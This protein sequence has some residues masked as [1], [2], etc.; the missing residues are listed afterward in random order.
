MLPRLRRYSAP[1]R[2]AAQHSTGVG[3]RCLQR[4][5]APP[6]CVCSGLPP[7][8]QLLRGRG[9]R[10]VHLIPF[11]AAAAVPPLGRFAAAVPATLLLRYVCCSPA[12][13]QRSGRCRGGRLLHQEPADVGNGLLHP[14]ARTNLL[15][16]PEQGAVAPQ[17]HSSHQRAGCAWHARLHHTHALLAFPQQWQQ[18]PGPLP[19]LLSQ[20]ARQCRG[21]HGTTSGRGGL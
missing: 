1:Q 20:I 8:G 10:K 14:C 7:H 5:K 6:L 15:Q 3:R 4:R 12:G 16:A 2:I 13:A 18:W 21:R 17:F 19:S 11:T 9:L